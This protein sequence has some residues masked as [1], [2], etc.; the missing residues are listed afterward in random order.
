MKTNFEMFDGV[1]IN[2]KTKNVRLG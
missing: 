2:P 1:L